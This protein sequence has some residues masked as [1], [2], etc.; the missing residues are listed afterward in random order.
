MGALLG[1]AAATGFGVSDFIGGMASRR[2][3]FLWVSLLS[4]FVAVVL[5]WASL[6]WTA[7]GAPSTSSLLWGAFSGVGTAV[8]TLALYRGLALGQMAVAGPLSAVGAA[9]LPALVGLILGDRL[10]PVAVA[11]VAV[12]FPALWLVARQRSAP[13]A[14]VRAGVVEGLVAGAGFGLLFVALDRAGDA[15]GLW[16]VAA[17]E[18]ASVLV[19]TVACAVAR[20]PRSGADASVVLLAAAAGLLAVVA[21]IL[22]F[23]ATQ[24]GLLT[25]AAVLSSLYPG[26]TVLLAAALLH[27]RPDRAQLLGLGLCAC[28]VTAI[29]AG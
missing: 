6:P 23:A 18:A 8:G 15:S 27:E 20:P 14:P 19:L 29:V 12:A 22:F 10:S 11:G 13:G 9:A 17:S 26:V 21:N 3:H 28:A 7:S 24:E 1:L 2:L 4:Q 5:A 25:V 16:P